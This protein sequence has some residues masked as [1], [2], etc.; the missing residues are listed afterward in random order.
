MPYAKTVLALVS[1]VL[2]HQRNVL[3]VL[4]T[5]FSM[6]ITALLHVLLVPTKRDLLIIFAKPVTITVLLVMGQQ[7]INV[8]VVNQAVI[9]LDLLVI[10][11]TQTVLLAQVGDMLI[12]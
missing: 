9:K 8:K 1:H 10:L 4:I 12:V 5:N 2:L 11:V 7:K 6:E 3:L